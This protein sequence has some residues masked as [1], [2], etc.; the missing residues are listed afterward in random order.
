MVTRAL[1]LACL[2]IVSGCG[3]QKCDSITRREASSLGS[4]ERGAQ[5]GRSSA[6]D[7]SGGAG[8]A[9]GGVEG[10]A[11]GET[12]AARTVARYSLEWP[13]AG[14]AGRDW[15]I[16][17]YFDREPGTGLLDYRGGTRTYEGH[18][19]VDIAIASLRVMDE[20]VMAHAVA[21]GVVTAVHDG[22]AD[23]NTAA[24]AENCRLVANSVYV[25]HADGLEGRYLHFRKGSLKVEVG[26]KIRAGDAL[27]LVGS[28][29]CSVSPHLHFELRDPAHGNVALD[30]FARELWAFPPAYEVAPSVMEVVFRAGSFSSTSEVQT[31]PPNPTSVPSGTVGFSVITGGTLQGKTLTVRFYERS[32][33]EFA[34]APY[35]YVGSED[36]YMR[37]WNPILNT[38]SWRAEVSIG[39]RVVKTVSFQ[40]N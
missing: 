13:L 11:S 36:H 26:Q 24:D 27:G 35:E 21:S 3:F 19:G 5:L 2:L 29:G 18:E 4:D 37:W 1:G 6:S 30:P 17:N 23:R 31:A 14:S 28:S 7:G 38:G 15:I 34:L 39:D 9:S 40:V 12:A 32:A 33:F 20:G 8:T 22:E 25:T 16:S 10:V